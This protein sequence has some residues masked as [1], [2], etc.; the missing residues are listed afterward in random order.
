M[1]AMPRLID[2][3]GV[4]AGGIG[5]ADFLIERAALL[6]YDGG[7]LQHVEQDLFVVVAQFGE[8]APARAV[9]RQRVVG[10][11]VA[12]GVLVEIHARVDGLVH[13]GRI[14]AGGGFRLRKGATRTEEGSEN[15]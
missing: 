3:G 5:I 1:G 14:Q 11:P 6:A 13:G 7:A 8:A 12:A 10:D 9:G 15:K 4:H 2:G